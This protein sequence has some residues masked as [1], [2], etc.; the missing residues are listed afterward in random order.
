VI[1]ITQTKGIMLK[2]APAGLLQ[3]KS[4]VRWA[5]KLWRMTSATPDLYSYFPS[6]SWYSSHLPTEGW[7]GW[8]DLGGWLHTE[9]VMTRHLLAIAKFLLTYWQHTNDGW[10]T[11]WRLIS[12]WSRRL[13][14]TNSSTQLVEFLQAA[15]LN[16]QVSGL[17]QH[18]SDTQADIISL[19][20]CQVK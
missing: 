14:A 15:T 13:R 1:H 9:T 18:L 8:V 4:E 16:V 20:P 17:R 11:I 2:I 12:C 10:H 5:R 19:Q 7:P 3:Q 6:L